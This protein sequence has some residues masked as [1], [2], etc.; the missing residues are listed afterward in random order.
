MR[1][2]RKHKIY[3]PELNNWTWICPLPYC[4]HV[5]P[6]CCFYALLPEF[7]F[8]GI[9]VMIY[10]AALLRFDSEIFPL[11]FD[12]MEMTRETKL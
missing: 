2:Q 8:S 4:S 3:P 11:K 6:H 9:H 7:V 1:E 12:W 10:N 5:P